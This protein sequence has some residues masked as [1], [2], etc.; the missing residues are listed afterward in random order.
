M[1]SF[2]KLCLAQLYK[3]L[4]SVIK[5]RNG[6]PWVPTPDLTHVS[7]ER[8]ARSWR[9]NEA[10]PISYDLAIKII[11]LD[12]TFKQLEVKLAN[13]ARPWCQLR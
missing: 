11:S 3:E 10:C 5:K 6:S 2:L 8:L 12:Q 7:Y 1:I 9:C 13:V 4:V